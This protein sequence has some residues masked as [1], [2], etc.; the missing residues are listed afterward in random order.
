MAITPKLNAYATGWTAQGIY[1]KAAIW[2]CLAII[3]SKAAQM[4]GAGVNALVGV[5]D[6]DVSKIGIAHTEIGTEYGKRGVA[7]YAESNHGP[8]GRLFLDPYFMGDLENLQGERVLDAGCGAAPW[9]I[10]AAK[11]GGD[12]YAIDIQQGMI[13]AA[14]VAVKRAGVEERVHVDQGD[15]AELPYE[16][17]FF[18]KEISIC[19]G[20]NLPPESFEKHFYECHRTLKTG[21]VAVIAAPNSLDVAFS[22][23]SKTKDERDRHIQDVLEKLPDNPTPEM[24]SEGL[25]QL[26]EVLSGTFYVENN[27]LKLVEDAKK[28]QE[29]QP[30]WRKL[31]TLVVPNRYYSQDYYMDTFKKYHFEVE[32]IERPH[33]NSEED[34]LSHNATSNSKLGPEYVKHAPFM[35]FHV[36]K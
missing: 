20:C 11:Q 34:R 21:G 15:V 8:D 14:R 33:F 28:L 35:I 23:G 32:K 5:A 19:V 1:R 9:A 25:L 12:V 10:Y 7:A 26:E 4:R 30:I 16:S 2:C 22:N 3:C 24:I 36:K 27:R 31:P 18:D 13:E 17:D 29:G 6:V